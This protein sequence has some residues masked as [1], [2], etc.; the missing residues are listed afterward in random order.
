MIADAFD[1]LAYDRFVAWLFRTLTIEFFSVVL[2]WVE[3]NLSPEVATAV[4]TVSA[5]IGAYQLWILNRSVA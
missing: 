1:V 3:G 5:T 2:G 4:G